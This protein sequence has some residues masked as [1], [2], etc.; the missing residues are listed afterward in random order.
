MGIHFSHYLGVALAVPIA[1]LAA[2]GLDRIA[3]APSSVLAV[4]VPGALGATAL[5]VAWRVADAAGVHRGPTAAFWRAD[6]NV[7][8]ALTAAVIIALAITLLAP[9]RARVAAVT[10]LLVLVSLEGFYNNSYLRPKRWDMFAHPAPYVRV[11][12][13]EARMTRVFPFGVPEANVNEGYGIFSVGSLMALNP[14]RIHEVY[15]EYAARRRRCSCAKRAACRPKAC[16]TAPTCRSS[17]LSRP[18]PGC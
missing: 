13:R 3:R 1:A 9:V 8:A 2:L 6:W 4:A 10:T 11:L 16:W 5:A 18:D 17:G 14:P 7:L 12:K 15:R